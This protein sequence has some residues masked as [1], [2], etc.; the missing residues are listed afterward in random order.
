MGEQ[1]FS[2]QFT[3]GMMRKNTLLFTILL[4]FY[5]NL[6][7]TAFA[8]KYTNTTNE[9][10]KWMEHY[11]VQRK[12]VSSFERIELGKGYTIEQVK[13]HLLQNISNLSATDNTLELLSQNESPVG[14]H[15]TFQQLYKDIPIYNS[16]IRV[17]VNRKGT[18]V[19][20]FE[21]TFPS[22]ALESI[23]FNKS[24]QQDLLQKTNNKYITKNQLIKEK[25]TSNLIW[26]FEKENQATLAIKIK[27]S[28]KAAN[29]FGEHMI[30][31]EGNLLFFRDLR[32]YYHSHKHNSSCTPALKTEATQSNS[33]VT[34][35]ALVFMPD[36]ITSSGKQYGLNGQYI[37]SEDA[38]RP[39]LNAER[40]VV[41]IDVKRS[42][43][44]YLLENTYVKIADFDPPFIAPVRPTTASFKYTRSESGFEDVNAYYHINAFRTHIQGLQQ[45]DR[46][47]ESLVNERIDVDTHALEGDDQ[48]F[49]T[50][51]NVHQL[52]FGEGGVDDAEDADVIVHEYCH[53][54]SNTACTDCNFGFQRNAID[55][56]LADYFAT[57][58]SRN[59]KEYNWENMFSWDGH[60][61]F[62]AGRSL[63]NNKRYPDDVNNSNY[64]LTG[65]IWG[66][67][68]MDVWEALGRD[69]TDM[70][71]LASLYSYSSNL[72]LEDVANILIVMDQE[73]WDGKNNGTLSSIL[74]ARGLIPYLVDAGDD[75]N[76]CVGDAL[77]LG[78]PSVTQY[79]NASVYW[80]PGISLNDS[81]L[82]TPTA[83]PD[84]P[85]EYVLTVVDNATQ[86]S[87]QDQV[88]ID[89][90]YCFD[91]EPT[92]FRIINTDRFM[93]GRGNLI[94]EIPDIEDV[95]TSIQMFDAM[96]HLVFDGTS[97]ANNRIEINGNG[98][99]AGLY[100]VYV[101]VGEGE[102][103]NEQVFKVVKTR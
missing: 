14:Q 26:F 46:T 20:V 93:K 6:T 59:I 103:E 5:I 55:E 39:E 95:T 7:T 62:F 66:A 58:Y 17:H 13:E 70:L 32:T 61:V 83:N 73:L 38:D 23:A 44:Q 40:V 47:F 27:A 33:A 87:Y 25:S 89:A 100:I 56:A 81:T 36:P 60:N 52:R 57:S 22:K 72:D 97:T 86:I 91:T 24:A 8:Q 80:S 34:A 88:F 10:Q 94:V 65:E 54:V 35:E 3:K 19:S 28:S 15:F 101:K 9:Q 90:K 37:D 98:L 102:G 74:A 49:Y 69:V 84:G 12:A 77:T 16:K 45:G 1:K 53:A 99:N 92:E 79:V 50:F 64:H 76:V 78:N 85:T 43:S 63:D 29:T 4:L 42:G 75:A 48:S 18:I 31:H 67:A 11:L 82:A 68:L 21:T 2:I 96:G 51:D 41:E 71:V 30:D